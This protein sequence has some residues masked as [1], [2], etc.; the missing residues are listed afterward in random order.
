[1]HVEDW[2][3]LRRRFRMRRTSSFTLRISW[4]CSIFGQDRRSRTENIGVCTG[5]CR[6]ERVCVFRGTASTNKGVV[7]AQVLGMDGRVYTRT[8]ARDEQWPIEQSPFLSARNRAPGYQHS[9]TFYL[10]SLFGV[11]N[12][13][14]KAHGPQAG[15]RQGSAQDPAQGK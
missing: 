1:M 5:A 12:G 8:T 3:V 13:T 9:G 11:K 7:S 15:T 4:I 10:S 6:S 2:T 14:H